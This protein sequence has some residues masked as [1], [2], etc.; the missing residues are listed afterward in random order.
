MALFAFSLFWLLGTGAKPAVVFAMVAGYGIGFGAMSG[1][2]GAFLSELF[3]T[4]YRYTGIATAR[5]LNGMLVAGPTPFIASALVAAAG[6]SPWLVAVY[7]IGCQALTIVG[8]TFARGATGPTQ[9]ESL[10]VS[11][12]TTESR[13]PSAE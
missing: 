1:A 11:S 4:R 13:R 10:G 12:Q 5:E 3:E 8:V 2:Q 6:G 9:A 7:L